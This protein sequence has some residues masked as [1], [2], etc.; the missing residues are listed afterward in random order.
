MML[1]KLRGRDR[2]AGEMISNT[3]LYISQAVSE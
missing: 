1:E 3:E 2:G